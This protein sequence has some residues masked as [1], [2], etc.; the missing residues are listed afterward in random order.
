MDPSPDKQTTHKWNR[1]EYRASPGKRSRSR[2]SDQISF[3]EREVKL[4][5]KA[6]NARL[7]LQSLFHFDRKICRY[8]F[9]I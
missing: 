4:I 8:S 6:R 7:S 9:T 3:G 5:L 2:L 1:L